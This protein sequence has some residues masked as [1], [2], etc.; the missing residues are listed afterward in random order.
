MF[1]FIGKIVHYKCYGCQNFSKED[2]A[3]ILQSEN[4]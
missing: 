4:V 3:Y 1:Y 2:I